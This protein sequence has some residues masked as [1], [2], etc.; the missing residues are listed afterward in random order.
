[1][2]FGEAAAG[3]RQIGMTNADFYFSC[4]WRV[5]FPETRNSTSTM[6]ALT[7]HDLNLAQYCTVSLNGRT[8][9]L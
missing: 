4:P 9:W 3:Y 2:A 7:R 5:A 8:A 6:R 1:M